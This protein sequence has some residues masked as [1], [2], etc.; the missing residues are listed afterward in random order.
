MGNTDTRK[1]GTIIKV[2][3]PPQKNGNAAAWENFGNLFIDSTGRRGTL[4]LDVSVDQLNNLLAGATDG[5]AKKKIA[6]FAAQRKDPGALGLTSKGWRAA[7]AA[8]HAGLSEFS[9]AAPARL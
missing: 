3:N 1:Q 7:A 6:I 9:N 8:L 4:Y 2:A 5:R